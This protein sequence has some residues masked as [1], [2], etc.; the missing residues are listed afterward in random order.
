MPEFAIIALVFFMIILG[1]IEFGRALFVINTLEEVTRR[2][3]RVAVVCD[4]TTPSIPENVALF[5][6]IGSAS[7]DSAILNNFTRNN[8]EITYLQEDLVTAATAGD[9]T[10]FV[11]A[12]IINY[13]HT[14]LIPLVGTD[15]IIGDQSN[16]DN[17]KEIRTIL[18]S[19]SLGFPSTS[20][21][22]P[23]P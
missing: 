3:A 15:L 21:C 20:T 16:P 22:P 2:A 17:S 10:Y 23:P 19:E 6:A 12:R 1:I 9:N 11:Q 5:N 18:P 8:I 4:R 7:N 13:T 14:L